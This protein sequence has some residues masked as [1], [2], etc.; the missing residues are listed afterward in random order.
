MREAFVLSSVG[1][2][3][4]NE[5]FA[6]RESAVGPELPPTVHRSDP[7]N[8]DLCGE[9]ILVR[10]FVGDHYSITSSARSRID[11]G[12]VRPS[13]LAVLVF[14]VITNLIGS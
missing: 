3:L 5:L 6:A 8:V 10:D 4:R 9:T 14:R 7:D 11:C 1:P 13:V 12:T 2:E